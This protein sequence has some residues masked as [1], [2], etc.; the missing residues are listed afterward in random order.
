[1]GRS[2]I[3]RDVRQ[4]GLLHEGQQLRAALRTPAHTHAQRQ[5]RAGEAPARLECRVQVHKLAVLQHAA[6]CRPPHVQSALSAPAA[7]WRSR[8]AAAAGQLHPDEHPGDVP[9]AMVRDHRSAARPAACPVLSPDRRLERLRQPGVR[10]AARRIRRHRR[11][12]RLVAASRRVDQR[13]PG[14]ARQASRPRIH[15]PGVAGGNRTGP[16]IREDRPLRPGATLLDA[17]TRHRRDEGP[18]RRYPHAGQ[19]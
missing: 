16:G 18:A 1:M 14:T 13:I 12:P 19:W 6:P 17:R 15:R 5:V 9:Q 8:L 7:S 2:R 11:D 4:R 3:F 10:G